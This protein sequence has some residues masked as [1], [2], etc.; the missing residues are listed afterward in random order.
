MPEYG[1]NP[2]GWRRTAVTAPTAGDRGVTGE[3]PDLRD[4]D[5]LDLFT[6]FYERV[7]CDP[8]LAP[9]FA[10]VDMPAHLPRIVD[11][12]S[13]M[14]FHT[15]RY[16]GSAFR[17]HQS[18]PGLA[19]EHF[20]RWLGALE[21]TVDERFAGPAAEQMKL[22]GHRVAYSMQLQLGITP[23]RDYPSDVAGAV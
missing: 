15:G 5:L 7:G 2:G 12:W 13:T 9:Y 21:A 17:P 20:V 6:S 3:R 8:L 22:F 14:L 4:E 19:P 1:V 23:A 11:F 18:M 10:A 16:S